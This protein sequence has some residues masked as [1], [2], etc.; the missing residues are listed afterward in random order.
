MCGRYASSAEPAELIDIFDV[1]VAPRTTLEPDYNVAPT[2]QVYAVVDRSVDDRLERLLTAV[3]W[4]LVPSWAKDARIGSRLI[5]ARVETAAEKPSFRSAWARRR[6]LLPAD[7][8]Y[9]WYLPVADGPLTATGKPAKQP[10][11]IHRR[12]GAPLAMAGLYEIWR[13]RTV[14]DPDAEGAWLWTT[15]VLTTTATDDMGRIHD[16]MPIDVARAQWAAWLD[17]GF[18]GDPHTLLDPA[19]TAAALVAYPVSTDV[20]NVRNNGAHLLDPLPASGG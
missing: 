18:S 15:T 19:A 11:F 8:Y 1:T 16:R 6:T 20:N 5:N 2:K 12:D 9:E 10:Y 13:D 17:P 7:G 3:R 14:E 4:G